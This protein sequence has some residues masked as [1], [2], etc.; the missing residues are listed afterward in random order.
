MI[1]VDTS[2]IFAIAAGERERDAFVSVLD[3]TDAAVCS[4]VT[5]LETVMVLTGRSRAVAKSTVQQLLRTFRIDV[6]SVDGV[7]TEAAVD[8]FDRYGKGRHHASLNLADCFSYAL[9][10]SRNAPLLFKGDDFARTDIAAA[11][12][13]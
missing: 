5:Y 7:V 12:Q 1:V 11:W 10:K 8:A 2:A 13:P 9:A 6:A 3:Q 4:S